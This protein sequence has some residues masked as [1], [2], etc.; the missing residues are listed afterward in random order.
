MVG[1]PAP[2]DSSQKK[3]VILASLETLRVK[4]L[5]CGSIIRDAP[6]S[7]STNTEASMKLWQIIRADLYRYCGK[8]SGRALLATYLQVPGFRYTFYLRKVAFYSATKRSFG[9]LP[10]IYNRLWLNHYR[11]RYGFEISPTTKIGPG[12]YI[13]HFGGVVISPYA[14]LGSNVNI[15]QGIT[16]GAAS[17]GARR[18]APTLGDRVWV[19]A[20]AI[21]VGKVTIGDDALIAPGAYVNFDVPE[22]SIV[23]GNPGKIV[24]TSGSAGYINN[25]LDVTDTA[26]TQ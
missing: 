7:G 3:Y 20:N 2:Q 25:T 19:G 8:T 1:L 11:F 15:A 24:S 6:N 9:L 5:V 21:I 18:G 14:I 23:I 22:K 13:G 10:Y 16:I 4:I 17:R 12:L 26:V